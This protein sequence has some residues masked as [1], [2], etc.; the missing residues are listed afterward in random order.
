MV[1]S[2]TGESQH[3]GLDDLDGPILAGEGRVRTD[4]FGLTGHQLVGA[5][6]SWKTYR[7]LDQR[8]GFVISEPAAGTK[9]R[10]LG[11]LL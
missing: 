4:F 10:N 3:H 11:G 5:L 1:L 6:Y 9:E 7:S 8:L 2:A